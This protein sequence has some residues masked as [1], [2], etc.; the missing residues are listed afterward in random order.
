VSEQGTT[1]TEPIRCSVVVRCSPERAFEAYTA[2]M[3]RWWPTGV[4]AVHPGQVAELVVDGRVGGAITERTGDGTEVSWADITV[5]DPPHRLGLAW[6]PSIEPTVST[7]IDIRFVDAGD[8]TTRVDVL[9]SGWERLGDRA[10]EVRASYDTGWT[11]VIGHYVDH[12]GGG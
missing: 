4:H 10:E 8:G 3:G 5:W 12:L 6:H 9:H 2:E 1:T 7:D 11:F